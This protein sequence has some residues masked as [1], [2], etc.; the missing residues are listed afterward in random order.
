VNRVRRLAVGLM[1][2]GL[3]TVT[4]FAQP[5]LTVAADPDQEL[6]ATLDGKPIPLEDVGK[7]NCDDFAYP[8]I[9]C[10]SSKVIADSR[11]TVVTLLTSIDYVTI[12]DYT[13]YAGASMNVSQD[14]SALVTIGW[15]DKISSF[16]ARNSETGTF[17]T[18]WFYTGTSFSFCCNTA[19][20]NLNAFNNTFSSIIRT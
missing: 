13:N 16:R 6:T 9:Q 2:T 7:Y 18:D 8:E 3:L 12:Y 1:A 17:W 14:Y 15:N 20:A 4:A 5:A 19:V 11:A 10:W